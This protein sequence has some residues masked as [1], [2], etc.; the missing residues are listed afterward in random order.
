MRGKAEEARPKRRYARFT[1]WRR[2]RFLSALAACGNARDAAEAAG[3]SLA[4][5]Y[6]ARGCDPGFAADWTR[7]Q[8]AADARLAAAPA[9]GEGLVILKGRGGRLRLS[10]AGSRFWTLAADAAFIAHLRATGNATAAARAAGFTPKSAYNRR[11][12]MPA[13]ARA[14]DAALDEA[15]VRL[16][17][18]M[19]AQAL[20]GPAPPWPDAPEIGEP[21]TFDLPLAMWLLRRRERM[22]RRGG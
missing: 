5:V 6:R 4:G 16:E 3:M 12:R 18:R 14:W 20:N 19:L 15:V 22:A 13:F 11:A 1:R 17:E 7:A 10:A 9:T 8:D 2:R 21:E